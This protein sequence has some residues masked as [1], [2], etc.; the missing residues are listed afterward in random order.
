MQFKLIPLLASAIALSI[1]T[2]PLAAQA[3]PVAPRLQ[4]AQAQ[5]KIPPRLEKLGLTQEQRDKIAEIRRNTR[6]QIEAVMTPAQREQ[7]KTVRESRQ[8]RREALASLNL[9]P[10]QK[11][12]MQQIRQ[13]AKSQFDAVL[14]PQQ[15]QQLQQMRQERGWKGRRGEL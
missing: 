14:T 12:K 15:Q 1:A 9:T 7:L 5:D 11:T 6:T 2:V 10:E 3:E 13:S 4:I 8:R